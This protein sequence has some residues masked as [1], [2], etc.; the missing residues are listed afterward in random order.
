MAFQRAAAE[1]IRRG[2]DRFVILGGQA[3]TQSRVL[4]DTPTTAYTTGTATA[5]RSGNTATAFGS[6]TTTV[7]GGQ[8]IL[9]NAHGQDLIV[10]RFKQGDPAGAN[11]LDARQELGP[12]W[13]DA[14]HK[15]TWTCL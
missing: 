3:Q 10:K 15:N 9:A 4:G 7:T 6:S 2:Y 8:P 12:A 5:T 11:A 13:Q 14:V 1:T